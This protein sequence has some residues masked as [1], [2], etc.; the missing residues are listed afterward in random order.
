MLLLEEH[1]AIDEPVPCP[2]AFLTKSHQRRSAQITQKQP[3]MAK[4]T[5][6]CTQKKRYHLCAC[7]CWSGGSQTRLAFLLAV[8]DLELRHANERVPCTDVYQQYTFAVNAY[9]FTQFR[10]HPHHQLSNEQ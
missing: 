3:R 8:T 2:Q 9:T 4:G 7:K 6:V 1:M 10:A 5:L